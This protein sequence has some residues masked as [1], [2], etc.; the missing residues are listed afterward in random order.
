MRNYKVTI[1]GQYKVGHCNLLVQQI[2]MK[3]PPR[4]V[5]NL[6]GINKIIRDI[7]IF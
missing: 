4:E 7:G 5:V 6:V 1:H 3:Q 2:A